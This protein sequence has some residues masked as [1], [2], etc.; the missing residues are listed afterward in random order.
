MD[1][2]EQRLA[3]ELISAAGLSSR[4]EKDEFIQQIAGA[5]PVLNAYIK[6]IESRITRQDDTKEVDYDCPSWSHKQADRNGYQRA[7]KEILKL[8]PR[9]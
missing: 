8:F 3:K 7:L 1:N 4:E 9:P 2:R 6:V 5:M